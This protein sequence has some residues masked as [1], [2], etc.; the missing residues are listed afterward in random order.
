MEGRHRH[1]EPRQQEGQR[2]GSQAE[3]TQEARGDRVGIGILGGAEQQ[4]EVHRG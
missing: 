2:Q 3:Q 1:V 4:T